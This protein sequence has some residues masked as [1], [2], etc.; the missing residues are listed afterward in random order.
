MENIAIYALLTVISLASIVSYFKIRKIEKTSINNE[1]EIQY[2]EYLEENKG[3]LKNSRRYIIKGQIFYKGLPIGS[4]FVVS[5]HII[6]EF[7][8]DKFKHLKEELLLPIA[9]AANTIRSVAS[10]GS[11]TKKA[12]KTAFSSIKKRVG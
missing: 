8:W 11:S 7:S 9:N 1:H 3:A 4:Q 2:F 10:V 5:E 6:E 12:A